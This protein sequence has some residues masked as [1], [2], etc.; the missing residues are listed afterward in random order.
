MHLELVFQQA[1]Y[2]NAGPKVVLC[3]V[4]SLLKAPSSPLPNA[5]FYYTYKTGYVLFYYW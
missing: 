3:N 5:Y 2:Y 1:E 4:R